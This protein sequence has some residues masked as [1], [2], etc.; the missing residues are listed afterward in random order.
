[1]SSVFSNKS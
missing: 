1:M